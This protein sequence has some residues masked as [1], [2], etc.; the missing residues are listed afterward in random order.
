MNV[1][2][3]LKS[4]SFAKYRLSLYNQLER[5]DL[6]LKR[7]DKL[8]RDRIPEVI[9]AQGKKVVWRIL[10]EEE[11]LVKLEEKL[12]EE[13]EEYQEDK[14]LEEM[15][16][17]LEVLYSI[18]SARGYTAAELEAEREKKAKNRGGFKDRIFLEYVD[19]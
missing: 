3:C 18:C 6:P 2:Y 10:T 4:V 16:D 7:Y 17:V 14:S 1:I 11:H 8:V 13:V 12:Y 5:G 9:Q 19:E 15:A